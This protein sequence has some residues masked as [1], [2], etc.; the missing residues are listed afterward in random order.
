MY[1]EHF[2]AAITQLHNCVSIIVESEEGVQIKLTWK[3]PSAR[4]Q[5]FLKPRIFVC[6]S[7]FRPH[8][9]SESDCFETTLLNGFFFKIHQLH[10][11]MW[12]CACPLA[13]IKQIQF[14]RACIFVCMNEFDPERMDGFVWTQNV[15]IWFDQPGFE[16]VWTGSER[17]IYD[18]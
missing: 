7:A 1:Q 5:I 8:E 10:R 17:T 11:F 9:T 14:V 18:N 15:F 16:F 12:I 6:K 3:A 2:L 13:S 4:I